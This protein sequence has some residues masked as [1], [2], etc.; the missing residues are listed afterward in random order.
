PP[1]STPEE[2]DRVS[3]EGFNFINKLL[4]KTPEEL[5]AECLKDL[6]GTLDTYKKCREAGIC[7]SE[8]YQINRPTKTDC[9]MAGYCITAGSKTI[10][11]PGVGG[12]PGLQSIPTKIE[13]ICMDSNAEIKGILTYR[14]STYVETNDHRFGILRHRSAHSPKGHSD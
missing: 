14:F 13:K 7:E 5:H 10:T 4:E 3:R 6:Q 12:V 8:A 1:K 2:L 11:Y 9:R